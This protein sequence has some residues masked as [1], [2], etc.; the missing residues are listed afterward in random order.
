LRQLKKEHEI[1]LVSVK[2]SLKEELRRM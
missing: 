1:E 2:T